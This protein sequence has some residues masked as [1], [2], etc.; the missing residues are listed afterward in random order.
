MSGFIIPLYLCDSY[1]NPAQSC[2]VHII[3]LLY[4]TTTTLCSDFVSLIFQKENVPLII[5]HVIIII[6]IICHT[7]PCSLCIYQTKPPQTK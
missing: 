1:F 6:I 7:V 4:K 2:F 5:F 3:D